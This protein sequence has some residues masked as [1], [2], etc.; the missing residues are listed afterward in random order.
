MDTDHN[1]M[2]IHSQISSF[3]ISQRIVFARPAEPRPDRSTNEVY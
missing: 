3:H 1:I 2:L